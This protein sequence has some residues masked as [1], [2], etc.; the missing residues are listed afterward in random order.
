[1][2]F[3]E[4]NIVFISFLRLVLFTQFIVDNMKKKAVLYPVKQMNHILLK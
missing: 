4:S 3:T 2:W 1:V